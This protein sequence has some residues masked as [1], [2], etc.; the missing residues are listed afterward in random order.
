MLV[1]QYN[2]KNSKYFWKYL[3]T[4]HATKKP[5]LWPLYLI[6]GGKIKT[7]D[8]HYEKYVIFCASH[9]SN[10]SVSIISLVFH[11]TYGIFEYPSRKE[12]INKSQNSLRKIFHIS[13]STDTTDF[14]IEIIPYGGMG[15]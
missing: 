5:F 1:K 9:V 3:S 10:S 4:T 2:Y 13:I 14:D 15:G 8:I 7:S 6:I 11:L 12:E